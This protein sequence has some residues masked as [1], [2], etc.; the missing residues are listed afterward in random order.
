MGDL[1]DRCHDI[2]LFSTEIISFSS[3]KYV[4]L[5]SNVHPK[6][7]FDVIFSIYSNT[8]VVSRD[9]QGFV[10]YEAPP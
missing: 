5:R 8:R 3:G 6:E 9:L 1:N 4:W 10:L 7:G 2:L